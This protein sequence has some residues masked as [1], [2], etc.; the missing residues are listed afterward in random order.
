M[1]SLPESLATHGSM[2][3]P[4]DAFRAAFAYEPDAEAL[5]DR[6]FAVSPVNDMANAELFAQVYKDTFAFSPGIGWLHYNGR[7]WEEDME[8]VALLHAGKIIR[9]R[10]EVAA[11]S[12]LVSN[13][14]LMQRQLENSG[15]R[16]ALAGML[17]LA[18]AI[19]HVDENRFDASPYYLNAQNGVIDLDAGALLPHA[20]SQYMTKCLGI[21]YNPDASSDIWLKTIAD[22]A[23][24]D[25][26]LAQFLQ[27]IGGYACS[28]DASAQKFFYF[29]GQGANGKSLLTD[30]GAEALG[31]FG[32]TGYAV[33]LPCETVLGQRERNAGSVSP[34]LLALRGRRLALFSEQS[35]DKPINPERLKDLTGNDA[36][37]ARA[38]HKQPITFRPSFTLIGCGNHKPLIHGSDYAIWR[39]MAIIHFRRRFTPSR[40]GERL[41]EPYHLQSVLSWMVR[42]ARD[43]TVNGWRIPESV[44][45]EAHEYQTE[46]DLIQQWLEEACDL[47]PYETPTRDLYASYAEW[48]E[49]GG[50]I[51]ISH[52]MFT[53]RMEHLGFPRR[54]TGGIPKLQGVRLNCASLAERMASS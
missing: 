32:R 26:E 33:R 38:P 9:R 10:T 2:L 49:L 52:S 41:L 51:R 22:I 6:Q 47:V 23:D 17:A 18:G 53:R 35:G 20:P 7:F 8:H 30:T 39:R 29:F 24:G 45:R 25:R 15:N 27:Q 40:L 1:S 54:K 31:G 14:K 48:C 3:K 4:P 44:Q 46:A 42:G 11:S 5:L 21:P 19:L 36:V 13:R 34:D 28:G 50:E 16:H 43:L 37:T 12:P